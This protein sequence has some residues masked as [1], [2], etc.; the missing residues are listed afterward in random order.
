[1]KLE[2]LSPI[3]DIEIIAEGSGIHILGYLKNRY[4]GRNWKKKKGVARVF[5]SYTGRPRLAEL[6]WFEAHGVGKVGLKRKRWLE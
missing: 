3:A 4:G 1:M 5:D 6:H 2:I